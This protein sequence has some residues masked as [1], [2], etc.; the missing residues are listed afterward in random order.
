[1]TATPCE[2][3]SCDGASGRQTS[4]PVILRRLGLLSL[5]GV[6][7]VLFVWPLAMLVIGAFRTASPGLEGAWTLQPVIEVFTG[8]SAAPMPAVA[9]WWLVSPR[10]SVPTLP[11]SL[12]PN[13]S[14]A[15]PPTPLYQ[16]LPPKP[17]SAIE[18][19]DPFFSRPY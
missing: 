1:M 4:S 17:P 10:W 15:T 16:S 11:A 8:P 14:R 19:L 2:T 3:L 9:N 6:L 18:A 13:R 7:A 5:F 12:K